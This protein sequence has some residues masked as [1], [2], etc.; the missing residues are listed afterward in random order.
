[1]LK[2]SGYFPACF[3]DFICRLL[4][5]RHAHEIILAFLGEYFLVHVHWPFLHELFKDLPS[6][7]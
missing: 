4:I 5:R 6:M 2:I 1:M 7:Q 3:V